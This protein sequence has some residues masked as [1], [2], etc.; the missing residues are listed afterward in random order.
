MVL[1]RRTGLLQDPVLRGVS[2]VVAEQVTRM[3][4]R[5]H[6]VRSQDTTSKVS[7]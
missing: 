2:I 5:A 7:E 6:R 1:L 4:L 3:I